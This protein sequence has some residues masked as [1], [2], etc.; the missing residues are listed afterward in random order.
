MNLFQDED[1]TITDDDIF[2]SIDFVFSGKPRSVMVHSDLI[3]FGRPLQ[4]RKILLDKIFEILCS[5]LGN[6]GTLLIPTFSY[7]DNQKDSFDYSN[8]KSQLGVLSEYLRKKKDLKRTFHPT[9]SFAVY[10]NKTNEYLKIKNEAFGKDS[11]FDKFY[12]ENGE[13]L[14]LGSDFSKCTF[15]HYVENKLS[16]KYRATKMVNL[17]T[18]GTPQNNSFSFQ[19]NKLRYKSYLKWIEEDLIS[20][21]YLNVDY[22][23]NGKIM[24]SRAK[25]VY[26]WASTVLK[27]N[28][29]AF[30]KKTKYTIYFKDLLKQSLGRL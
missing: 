3:S 29:Q 28:P 26:D 30:V 2:N 25:D 18:Q 27:T 5:F 13:I 14:F 21:K 20:K 12:K 10:G 23:S 1:L 19:K 9:H 8:S 15:I 24:A 22:S 4:S 6:S 16:C 17:A 11:I 7:N